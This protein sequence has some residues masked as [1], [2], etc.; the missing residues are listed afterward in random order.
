M[1]E[2]LKDYS[3]L[4]IHTITTRP[5]TIE[6]AAA[7]FAAAGVRGITVWRDALQGRDIKATG[8]ILRENGLEI[9]SLCRGGFF[10]HTDKE[11]RKQAI[12]DNLRAIDEAAALGAPLIVLVCGSS[13]SQP[14]SESRAQIR[15]GI[16]TILPHAGASGVRLAIEPLHPMYADDR[17]AINTL[18]QANDMAGQIGSS[19]VG[20]AVDVYHLWWDPE[21]EQEI[22]RCGSNNHLFA[23]HICDWNTPTTDLLLDRGLMG[24]GCI[25]I[26]KIR[27]WVEATGFKGF[28]EVEIFS[29]KYWSGD[30]DVFLE[31]ITKAYLEHS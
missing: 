14:L 16:E 15:E 2:M 8:N 24:D 5:W 19:W 1:A 23:F 18:K 12:D 13:V 29:T 20:V 27:G 3:R 25:D 30:Q 9:V 28:N 4:C 26:R 31:K 7:K 6:T 21:L 10:P 22:Y 11:K 17:S